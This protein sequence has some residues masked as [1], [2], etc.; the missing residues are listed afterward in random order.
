MTTPDLRP[1]LEDL[2]RLGMQDAPGFAN[3]SVDQLQLEYVTNP[4]GRQPPHV[5]V[6]PDGRVERMTPFQVPVPGYAANVVAVELLGYPGQPPTPIQLQSLAALGAQVRQALAGRVGFTGNAELIG[7]A[8]GATSGSPGF[9]SASGM[10]MARKPA[11]SP[12]AAMSPT[13][14]QDLFDI[15][16]TPP[17]RR[18]PLAPGSM[19]NSVN[20]LK[21]G[22][23]AMR[24]LFKPAGARTISKLVVV[25]SHDA[26][27][28]EPTEESE[29]SLEALRKIDQRLGMSDFRG[30]YLLARNGDLIEGR[31][32]GVVGNC[33]PGKN[34]AAIQIV[35]AGNGKSP[36]RAQR[37]T[38][39]MYAA[40]MRKAM[41][42][43]IQ[44]A[45]RE[46]V[47]GEQLLGIDPN[48]VMK[49]DLA[50]ARMVDAE[51]P[52]GKAQ[53]AG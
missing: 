22:G 38:L 15:L 32:L 48:G 8:N 4:Y 30:H 3:R 52:K 26:F 39:Y 14:V 9:M 31:D 44:A 23:V 6:F 28:P 21:S 34:D 47:F 35:V 12:A 29:Y 46:V 13:K 1:I 24:Q 37:E 36:T 53:K 42:C 11:P 51:L 40:S 27:K 5:L 25:A 50:N 17:E 18:T 43:P 45:V 2:L 33:W 7:A 20:N 19:F 49:D 10:T 16:G 41:D